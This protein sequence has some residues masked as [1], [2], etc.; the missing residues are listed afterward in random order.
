MT[1]ATNWPARDAGSDAAGPVRYYVGGEGEPLLLAARA[2]R[3]GRR[4]GSRCCRRSC[5]ATAC[6]RVDLPGHARLGA[7][8]RAGR[9]WPTSPPLRRPC[10]RRRPSAGAR[11]RPLVR[12]AR[13]AAARAAPARARRAACCSSS[14]AGIGSATRAAQAARARDGD[15]P[16]RAAGRAAPR[17]ATRERAWYRRALFRPWFVSDAAAL[18]A[19]RDARAARRAARAHRHEDRRAR[20]GRRRPAPRPRRC[21]CPVVV[22]WGARDAQLPLD[23]AFE[24]ARRLRREAPRRR[25]LR[26]PRDRR[27]AAAVLDALATWRCLRRLDGVLELEMNSQSRSNRSASRC[28][29]RLH[30]EPL[31][32]VV[33]AAT[34]W[35]PSSRAVCRLGSSGSPVRKR[36]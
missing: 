27:A 12:R 15:D 8:C 9:A 23:D 32:R 7:G 1:A 25:R 3:L 28:G 26:P 4:T 35:I 29:E 31:G 21:R 20:D 17:T 11:R 36:S 10:S 33:A 30:A 2:R 13:R 6:S 14:P 34:K 22:L 19:A 16:A 18:S 5:S 24:Y